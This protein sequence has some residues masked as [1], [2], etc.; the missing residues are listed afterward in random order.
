MTSTTPEVTDARTLAKRHVLRRCVILFETHEGRVGYASFGETKEMC[1]ST[2]RIM[3]EFFDDIE[4]N[5]HWD[6]KRILG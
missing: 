3:D 6:S 2:R 5:I 4:H 1:K